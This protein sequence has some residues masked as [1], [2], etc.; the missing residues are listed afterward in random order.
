MLIANVEASYWKQHLWKN[1][2][3]L[4]RG[5]LLKTQYFFQEAFY[6]RHSISLKSKKP[7]GQHL[8]WAPKTTSHLSPQD[9]SHYLSNRSHIQSH[10]SEI[11]DSTDVRLQKHYILWKTAYWRIVLKISR[12]INK[13]TQHLKIIYSE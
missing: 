3:F 10:Q 8:I 12:K 5:I 2:V 1:T 9:I 11:D 13:Y 6:W 7:V 4:S